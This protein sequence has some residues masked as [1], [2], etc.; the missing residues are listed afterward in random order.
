MLLRGVRGCRPILLSCLLS[1]T[2][3]CAPQS[4]DR[5][6]SA[7]V[8]GP[9]LGGRRA[10]SGGAGE[11][12]GIAGAGG[13]GGGAG[14]TGG[15]GGAAGGPGTGGTAG[16]GATGGNGASGGSG[17][18][19]APDAPS[20]PD[21]SPPD[22]KPDAV[23]PVND[24]RAASCNNLPTWR[25]NFQYTD[26]ADVVNLDPRRRFE[27]R[28]WP[29]TPWCSLPDYEPGRTKHWIDAWIDRGMCP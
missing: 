15:A 3:V 29:Y 6:P 2:A 21:V 1:L 10:P 14:A 17:G 16:T 4:A 26:G 8:V 18:A 22:M 28:P 12:G 27:C 20:E 13:A 24:A 7:E 23:Y 11:G 5:T 25:P 9:S 19:G